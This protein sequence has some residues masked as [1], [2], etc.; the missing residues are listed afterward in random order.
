MQIGFYAIFDYTEYDTYGISIYFPDFPQCISCSKT[1]EEGFVMAKEALE[2]ET[3]TM[4]VYKLPKASNLN[5][6]KLKKHEK[7]F[8]ISYNTEDLDLTKFT[9]Y[10]DS[11]NT[12][13]IEDVHS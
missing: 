8:F 6:L 10:D 12:L 1:E 5:D 3:I 2:L 13:P 4:Q 9:F 7:A 11:G